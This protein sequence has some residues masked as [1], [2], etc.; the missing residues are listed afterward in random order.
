MSMAREYEQR[1]RRLMAIIVFLVVLLACGIAGLFFSQI[2]T[3]AG[4]VGAVPTMPLPKPVS[5]HDVKAAGQIKL[6]KV[7]SDRRVMSGAV[8]LSI[9]DSRNDGDRPQVI[10]DAV[11]YLDWVST[12]SIRPP[13]SGMVTRPK[14]FDVVPG[15]FSTRNLF[16]HYG[17]PISVTHRGGPL[18]R[19]LRVLNNGHTVCLASL[20][21]VGFKTSFAIKNTGTFM[22]ADDG[23]FPVTP[24]WIHVF[25][26]SYYALSDANGLFSIERP[27]M[28]TYKLVCEHAVY[29]RLERELELDGGEN[30]VLIQIEFDD[31][32]KINDSSA[33]Q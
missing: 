23:I 33:P 28:G 32:R 17:Q 3:R 22:S 10:Q 26:H 11:V 6:T 4:V 29:G 31:S 7:A 2:K 9:N 20:T 15:G 19:E 5:N 13:P 14:I 12:T 24:S 18:N 27:P 30:T 21:S 25:Q 8:T 16:V 1:Q